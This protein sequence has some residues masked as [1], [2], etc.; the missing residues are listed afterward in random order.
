MTA[1]VRSHSGSSSGSNTTL[2]GTGGTGGTA[3]MPTMKAF[4]LQ[5]VCVV[6]LHAMAM[7]WQAICGLPAAPVFLVE[8]VGSC[9]VLPNSLLLLIGGVMI[10]MLI[11]HLQA[12]IQ[13]RDATIGRLEARIGNTWVTQFRITHIDF[14]STGGPS[15]PNSYLK[16]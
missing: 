7:G 8:L 4:A 15:L 13:T 1:E 12:T 11:M 2:P 10:N 5:V 3:G 14:I 6:F 16:S 9:P